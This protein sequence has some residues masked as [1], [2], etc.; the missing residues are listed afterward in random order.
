LVAPATAVLLASPALNGFAKVVTK[1]TVSQSLKGKNNNLI[2]QV[3]QK[4]KIN[5]NIKI[6]VTGTRTERELKNYPGSVS[7]FDYD[8]N[9]SNSFTSWRDYFQYEPG[10]NSQDFLRSDGG[11][12]YAKG[13][14]GNI[15]IR[16]LEGNRILTQ[17]DGVT[18]PR[19]NYGNSTFSVGRLNFIDFNT[20]GKLE[21]LKG[22]GSSL[23]GSDA[24]GGV[25]SLESIRPDDLL[26]PGDKYSFEIPANYSGANDSTNGAI[27]FAFRENDF[28][29]I[30]VTSKGS[31]NELNRKADDKYIDDYE[32]DSKGLYTK[33]IKKVGDN[34]EFGITFENYQKESESSTKPENLTGSYISA[35]NEA[36]SE[37]TRV[38]I[39]FDYASSEDST[40]DLIKGSLYF[41][42]MDY[43]NSYKERTLS[44]GT[45]N[46]H[47][48]EQDTYG[49][50]LQ[51]SNELM[52]GKARNLFSYG[53]EASKFNGM[54]TARDYAPNSEGIYELKSG[55]PQKTVPETDVSKYG[56]Y[57]QNEYSLGDLEII[58]G[59][60]YDYYNLDSI[61]DDDWLREGS[62]RRFVN[63]RTAVPDPV[64][65][66]SRS[67]NPH[68]AAILKV[69]EDTSI[70]G[71]Y[72]RGFRAPTW[73]EL[74]SS[75]F[76]IF[77]PA[78]GAGYAT[79]GDPDLDPEKS[80]SF[81]I[82]LRQSK[83]KYDFEVATFYNKYD[84]FIEKSVNDGDVMFMTTFGYP[85]SI[86]VLR[87][88]NVSEASIYGVEA[89]STFYFDEKDKGLSLSNALSL[90]VGNDDIKD[91][92]LHS[93]NPFKLVSSLKYK[94]PGEKVVAK[95]TNTFTG[96]PTVKDSYSDF[97]PD[98]WIKTDLEV[99]V[100]ISKNLNTSIG[101]FNVFDTKYYHWSDIR[102]SSDDSNHQRYA[103]AGRHLKAGFNYKF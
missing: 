102:Q 73:E 16:G 98:S 97:K 17:V 33:I 99:G 66:S 34:T 2:A 10:I 64:D 92:P 53:L 42:E 69:N 91:E 23:Y 36:D 76:N 103:Q 49:V 67:F 44:D 3:D 86:P 35:V 25:V 11:R 84:D 78:N 14:K 87:S 21:V 19:F 83:P 5:G 51:V 63:P 7:V 79:F 55:Y 24:I 95:V 57:L 74:N 8:Y 65:I 68:L 61:K 38:S 12:S 58:G 28:E 20:I 62:T 52:V 30:V 81:E 22:S 37:R 77:G 39:D 90:T 18:I 88:K 82:G 48:L 101:A 45:D 46:D 100:N 41:N 96:E 32:S 94:F 13:D 54:R 15:N 56:I 72:S 93:I 27:K 71:K 80:D 1:S 26:K 89:K 43:E 6:T 40:F 60:R 31:S 4:E 75:H 9:G 59:I 47:D 29:G 70:Y 50:N 85:I